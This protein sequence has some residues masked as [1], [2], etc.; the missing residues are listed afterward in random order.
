M[1]RGYTLVELVIGLVVSMIVL[2]ILVE[3][4]AIMSEINIPKVTQNQV[5]ER[6]IRQFLIRNKP[7]RC[8]ESK[9]IGSDYTIEMNR[10]RIVKTNPGYEIL[11]HNVES[12]NPTCL[13]GLM[14][15]HYNNYETSFQLP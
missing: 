7:I 1:K 10:Q 11:L 5:F 9:I 8:D 15:I 6:Q 13:D 3:T 4:Y 14:K 2:E 12:F